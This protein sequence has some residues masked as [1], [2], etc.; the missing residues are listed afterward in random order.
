MKDIEYL[1]L[2]DEI[3]LEVDNHLVLP[4][5]ILVRLVA[6]SSDVIHSWGLPN[7]F[8]KFDV[9]SGVIRVINFNF[10]LLGIFFGQCSE[11]CGAN[12]SFIPIVL[13][14]VLFDFFKFI[15]ISY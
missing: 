15:L 4:N 8:L 6:T 13:D 5:D 10:N 7:F 9:I 12:H 11:I 14:V 3:F 1:I 2:G